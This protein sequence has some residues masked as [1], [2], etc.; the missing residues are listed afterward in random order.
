MQNVAGHPIYSTID[1]TKPTSFGKSNRHH[2]LAYFSFVYFE[3]GLST[4][5][6]TLIVLGDAMPLPLS[7]KRN[8]FPSNGA[9]KPWTA[10][11]SSRINTHIWWR[12]YVFS[13][14]NKKWANRSASCW[15]GTFCACLL[16]KSGN[17]S[18]LPPSGIENDPFKLKCHTLSVKKNQSILFDLFCWVNANLPNASKMPP[19]CAAYVIFMHA[20]KV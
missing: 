12:L 3:N 1:L 2:T 19:S 9:L 14:R 18:S 5:R 7:T 16:P 4:F 6:I 11:K 10:H 17:Q 15:K 8:S 13:A 20:F